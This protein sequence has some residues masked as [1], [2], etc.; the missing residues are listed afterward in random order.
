M[1]L[2]FRCWP[3]LLAAA[4]L[5]LALTG[6]FRADEQAKDRGANGLDDK[7]IR[8]TI[9]VLIK[10]GARLHNARDFAGSY[11]FFQGGA[12]AMRPILAGHPDLL[13]AL[14]ASLAEAERNP[15]MSQRAWILYRS[16]SRVYSGLAPKETAGEQKM[17]KAA[18]DKKKD[19]KRRD[20]KK[21]TVKKKKKKGKKD[22]GK[23]AKKD[24]DK[25]AKEEKKDKDQTDDDKDVPKDL[26]K[27]VKKADK[28][29][30]DK[31]LKLDKAENKKEKAN[32][33]VVGKV[34]Y[35]GKPLAMGKVGFHSSAGIVYHGKINVDGTYS[36]PAIAPGDYHVTVSSP[37]PTPPKKRSD[38]DSKKEK[39]E[40]EDI[41]KRWVAIPVK[42]GAADKTGLHFTVMKGEG[43]EF[44]IDLQP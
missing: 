22:K 12:T 7:Q 38:K 37:K 26:L 8:S 19:K 13:K 24:M 11:R 4:I 6:R 15:S 2:L 23:D 9:R 32:A 30:A 43:N 39:K 36:V 5:A 31:K 1:R 34:T 25:P 17:E 10:G 20:S 18:Q 42:Y 27:D 33:K 28:Q 35:Q 21:K 41:V 3:S 29:K 40:F 44:N 16:L 14:D